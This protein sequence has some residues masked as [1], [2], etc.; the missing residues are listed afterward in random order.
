MLTVRHVANTR[1]H[2]L[3]YKAGLG[4]LKLS[5]EALCRGVTRFPLVDTAGA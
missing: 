5:P 2:Y 1:S 3:V 4:T